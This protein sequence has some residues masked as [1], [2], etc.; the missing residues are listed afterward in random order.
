MIGKLDLS[1]LE[2]RHVPL[3]RGF[4]ICKKSLHLREHHI[5]YLLLIIALVVKC[6][7]QNY[8]LHLASSPLKDL[9]E[10]HFLYKFYFQHLASNQ[11]VSL[12]HTH[13]YFTYDIEGIRLLMQRIGV[14]LLFAAHIHST[15][16]IIF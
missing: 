1:K 10:F 14:S 15:C 4:L 12:I 8:L 2:Q 7:T 3:K 16:I 9:F 6:A 5:L 11:K 13:S